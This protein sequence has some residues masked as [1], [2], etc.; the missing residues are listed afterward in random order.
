MILDKKRIFIVDDN[1][2]NRVIAILILERAGAKTAYDRWGKDTVAALKRF[3]PVDLILLD[4][5]FPGNVTGYNVFDEIRADPNFVSV[6]IV[7]VSATD[8]ASA[9]PIVRSKGF[10]GFIRKPVDFLMLP[11]QILS[12]LSGQSIWER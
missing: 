8:P 10:A 2:E 12:I 1:I 9:L 5:M 3:A 4:L 7:A 6:P 11:R